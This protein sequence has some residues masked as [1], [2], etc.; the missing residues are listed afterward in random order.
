MKTRLLQCSSILL[1]ACCGVLAQMSP[2][3]PANPSQTPAAQTTTGQTVQERLGYPANSR[4]LIIHG[5]D[6][7]MSHSVNRGTMEALENG[8]ITSASIMVPCP[9]FPEVAMWA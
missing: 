4:L 1:L 5:D 9:W 8:W 6:F 2:A 7:G 3:Q